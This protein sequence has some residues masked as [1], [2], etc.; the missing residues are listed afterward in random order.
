MNRK[1]GASL[2]RL[3]T[4]PRFPSSSPPCQMDRCPVCCRRNWTVQ[5]LPVGLGTALRCPAS[6]STVSPLGSEVESRH[7]KALSS[8]PVARRIGCGAVGVLPKS[9]IRTGGFERQGPARSNITRRFNSN[10]PDNGRFRPGVDRL[11]LAF[12]NITRGC[13]PIRPGKG[14]RSRGSDGFRSCS[15]RCLNSIIRSAWLFL[16]RL[17]VGRRAVPLPS[18]VRRLRPTTSQPGHRC[19]GSTIR[20]PQTHNTEGLG[21]VTN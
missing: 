17:D 6:R 15:K 21:T 14:C 7:P 13:C 1:I 2:S 10:R 18:I 9:G 5:P 19:Q 12:T 11:R 8:R 3:P 4:L 16:P 20:S